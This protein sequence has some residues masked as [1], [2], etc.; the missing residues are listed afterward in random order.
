LIISNWQFKE[1][2]MPVRP[3]TYHRP[4]TLPD[5][6]QALQ[7]PDTY[8]LGGGTKLLAGHM[9]LTVTGVVDLQRLGLD[10][11]ELSDGGLQV[12]AT[13][14]LTDWADFLAE[15]ADNTPAAL[16]LN[17]IRRSGPNTYRNAATVGGT[18]ASRLPDSELLA[19]LLVLDAQ[20]YLHSEETAVS[21]NDYLTGQQSTHLIT[22]ITIP[23][24]EGQGA[25]ERVARTPADYPIVSITGW[26][27]QSGSLRI[28]ATG[29]AER[30]FRL[31]DI[32]DQ[33]SDETID[34]AAETARNSAVHPGDFRGD[35]AYRA[36]MAAVLTRRVLEQVASG[37]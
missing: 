28:A 27:G 26:Q 19:A 25:S 16:L 8:P 20:V 24:Q 36:E 13:V 7:T 37:K 6:W 10:Q 21:L 1:L 32:D 5:A 9:P 15:Q 35:A 11:I 17:G 3:Q 30:P 22:H 31:P 29:L 14:R 2:T 4:E 23:W 33:L 34:A 18:L 12:G